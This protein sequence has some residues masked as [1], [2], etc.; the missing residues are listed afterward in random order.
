MSAVDPVTGQP[1]AIEYAGVDLRFGEATVLQGLDLLVPRGGIT[2]LAGRSGA[3]KSVMFKLA[4]GLLAPTSGEVR[5]GGALVGALSMRQLRALRSDFGV[6]FQHAALFDSMSVFDNVAFPLREH[7]RRS[8]SDVA[9]RVHHLLGQVGL[10][11][12][13][14]KMPSELSGGMQ[15]WVGLARALA[16]EPRYLFYD[17][18]TSGL[19]PVLA[20][21]MYQ[22]VLD[23]QRSRPE[24][25]SFVI[26]HDL[27]A[28]LAIADKVALLADKRVAYAMDPVAFALVDDPL[29]QRFL[30]PEPPSR[31]AA[32]T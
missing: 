18:P 16:R 9:D 30:H 20:S 27:L 29:V 10:E 5:V 12:S 17:E 23:T 3:G 8:R 15:K 7:E 32:W 13:A 21:A 19:D 22:L 25:T 6:V 31:R 24:L 11:G 28:A 1:A 2:V 4:L 14:H 26:S